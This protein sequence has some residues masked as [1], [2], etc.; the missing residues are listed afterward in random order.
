MGNHHWNSSSLQ[1]RRQSLNPVKPASKEQDMT[2]NG[3]LGLVFPR[4]KNVNH[5]GYERLSWLRILTN[6]TRKTKS[7]QRNAEVVLSWRRSW[8]RAEKE[9]GVC[10]GSRKW[11]SRETTTMVAPVSVDGEEE[12]HD[13]IGEQGHERE[14]GGLVSSNIPF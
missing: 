2:K 12:I 14:R 3:A 11:S 5:G 8:H 13:G 4:R 1:S 7:S 9:D 6:T 10:G